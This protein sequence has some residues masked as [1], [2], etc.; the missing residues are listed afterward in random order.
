P[1]GHVAQ[2]ADESTAF[3]LVFAAG[4]GDGGDGGAAPAVLVA[5]DEDAPIAPGKYVSERGLGKVQPLGSAAKAKVASPEP[6]DA[7]GPRLL[8]RPGGAWL[9]WLAR[10]PEGDMTWAVE[11][12][13]EQRSY[14][15]IELVALD[16]GGQPV[17]PVRRVSSD[18]GRV[19]SFSLA[20]A[21]AGG[22]VV[23]AVDESA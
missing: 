1:L 23:V 17:G 12:P 22:L 9:A 13:A 14:R 11:G 5:W 6:S 16:L 15:W 4:G 7:E 20:G 19:T 10:R 2:Q 3:D 8:A 18:R 21:S